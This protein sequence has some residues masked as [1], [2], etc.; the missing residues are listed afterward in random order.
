[1]ARVVFILR[2][3]EDLCWGTLFTPAVGL[4]AKLDGRFIF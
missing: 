3:I 1:M 2:F 4:P